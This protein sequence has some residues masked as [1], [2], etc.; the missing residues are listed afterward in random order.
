MIVIAKG[1]LHSLLQSQSTTVTE[2]ERYQALYERY[3]DDPTR[4]IANCG[5]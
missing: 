2:H 5:R 3:K 1:V 4:C